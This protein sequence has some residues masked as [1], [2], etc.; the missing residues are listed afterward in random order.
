MA[1]Q[2]WT[3]A[4][5]SSQS[6]RDFTTQLVCTSLFEH[7][8]LQQSIVLHRN[9]MSCAQFTRTLVRCSVAL[10]TS[11]T[12]NVNAGGQDYQAEL[13]Q[14]G[15]LASFSVELELGEDQL[16]A[17]FYG[18]GGVVVAPYYIYITK[19]ADEAANVNDA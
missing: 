13:E 1:V 18:R 11:L 4:G 9:L 14:D 19:E 6:A 3:S 2:R 12:Y 7:T 16:F 17:A 5:H 10:T 8:L 15:S